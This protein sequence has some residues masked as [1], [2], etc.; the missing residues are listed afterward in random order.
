MQ[1]FLVR[2]EQNVVGGFVFSPPREGE[3]AGDGIP[4]G[5]SVGAYVPATHV[6]SPPETSRTHIGLFLHFFLLSDGQ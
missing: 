1:R 6:S 2:V 5:M 3:G 4:V